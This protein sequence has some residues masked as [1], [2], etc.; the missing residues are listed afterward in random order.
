MGYKEDEK[1]SESM[2]KFTMWALII[3]TFIVW[4]TAKIYRDKQYKDIDVV[5]YKG[6][7]SVL[8]HCFNQEPS[9]ETVAEFIELG[10]A[11]EGLLHSD[12]D[13]YEDRKEYLYDITIE[14]K[15][16]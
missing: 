11:Y 13:T 9:L 10:L 5:F 16:E 8:Y 14:I 7:K 15:E 1:E 6:E 2:L 12:A 4:S 3:L